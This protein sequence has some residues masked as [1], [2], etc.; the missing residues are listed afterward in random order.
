MQRMCRPDPAS[1]GTWA[2]KTFDGERR[3]L[4]QSE[5]WRQAARKAVLVEHGNL[6]AGSP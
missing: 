5:W 1:A 6:T 2:E 4:L 3:G